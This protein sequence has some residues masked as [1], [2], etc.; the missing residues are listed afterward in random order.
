[1]KLLGK[2]SGFAQLSKEM[3]TRID[4]KRRTKS[5]KN[6]QE[7]AEEADVGKNLHREISVKFNARS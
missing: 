7:Q 5:Y 4:W 6:L 3:E 2:I 1:V